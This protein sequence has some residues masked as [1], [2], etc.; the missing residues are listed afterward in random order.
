MPAAMRAA[1][2]S[3]AAVIDGDPEIAAC[4]SIGEIFWHSSTAR[5]HTFGI[6]PGRAPF[7]DDC[8]HAYVAMRSP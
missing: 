3:V 8:T 6:Q 1:M 2:M 4:G 7:G 5:F